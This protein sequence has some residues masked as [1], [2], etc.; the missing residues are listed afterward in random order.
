MGGGMDDEDW[1]DGLG[2]WGQYPGRVRSIDQ[3]I[4]GWGVG[5]LDIDVA[6]VDVEIVGGDS[7][8]GEIGNMC[9][10]GECAIGPW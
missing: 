4:V 10:D 7:D 6:I 9:E 1:W 3:E 5:S 8:D 2:D